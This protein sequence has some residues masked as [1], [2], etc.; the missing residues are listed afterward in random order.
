MTPTV[1][2]G[3]AAEPEL[4][5]RAGVIVIGGG[6]IG[7]SVAYHL[8]RSGES[9]VVLLERRRITSGT[10][11]HA[12]GL[13]GQLRQSVTM[14]NLARYTS[15]L[16]ARLE[17][18]TGQATGYRRCGSL[19]VTADPE[20]FEELRR[21]AS[22]AKVLGLPVDVV[23]PKTIGE[24]APLLETSDLLGGLHIPGDGYAN[25]TDVTLALA[26]GARAAGA[27]DR[28][29]GAGDRRSA[30]PGGASSASP[31]S[32]GT[33]MPTASSSAPAC[34]PGS[35]PPPSA[36]TCRCMPASTTTSGSTA[37]RGSTRTCP[38]CGTTTPSRTSATTQAS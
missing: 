31:R 27:R 3:P 23:T 24:R 9:D 10:T 33:S 15:E 26:A 14:T 5:P 35:W 13:L 1:E 16:Y 7:C 21:A 8:A 36:S 6:V 4:P 37:S 17:Q 11:W 20:R 28:R 19:S 18:E 12:A 2:P 29:A 22:L 34:G 30:P 38:S 25:P 32:R